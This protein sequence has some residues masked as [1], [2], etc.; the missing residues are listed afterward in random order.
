MCSISF[1]YFYTFCI[2]SVSF[3][4]VLAG[5]AYLSSVCT[6]LC[7]VPFCSVLFTLVSSTYRYVR[8]VFAE[9]CSVLFCL[10]SFHF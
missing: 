4:S 5:F 2:C 3:C 8:F 9:L 7:S 1:V 10:V 6:S